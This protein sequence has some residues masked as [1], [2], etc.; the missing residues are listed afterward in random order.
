MG[1]VKPREWPKCPCGAEAVYWR[2]LKNVQIDV[3][4]YVTC[5]EPCG[6]LNAL[7]GDTFGGGSMDWEP[8]EWWYLD[9]DR[10]PSARPGRDANIEAKY[11]T[12]I[13]VLRAEPSS[14]VNTVRS[15]SNGNSGR[16]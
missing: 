2:Y 9:R 4:N 3:R 11:G 13:E 15:A 8:I 6:A 7:A 14:R 1:A 16:R 10:M 12:L 5:C